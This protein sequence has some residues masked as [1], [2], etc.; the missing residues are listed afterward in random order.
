MTR[1][2]RVIL[3]SHILESMGPIKGERCLQ[4]LI[5]L[6]Q[7]Y[8]ESLGYTF[9][10]DYYGPVSYH[11]ESDIDEAEALGF[12][13]ISW[14]NKVPMYSSKLQSVIRSEFWQK[15][16]DQY[17]VPVKIK[18]Q[19]PK[20]HKILSENLSNPLLMETMASL[21]Y[22]THS[23]KDDRLASQR[24]QELSQG[25]IDTSSITTART[26]LEQLT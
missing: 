6:L 18:N 2:D 1:I 26:M 10:W 25:R 3:L 15:H 12:V 24:L 4:K 14:Q 21:S 7:T 23:M 20:L 19:I 9:S 11:I 22:L 13:N 16:L 5:Y 17:Q 8:G